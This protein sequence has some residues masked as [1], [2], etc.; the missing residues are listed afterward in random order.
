MQGTTSPGKAGQA[1]E[2]WPVLIPGMACA[3]INPCRLAS[4]GAQPARPRPT[5]GDHRPYAERALCAKDAPVTGTPGRPEAPGRRH[6]ASLRPDGATG[7]GAPAAV[8][9]GMS[10]ADLFA[11]YQ[12]RIRRYILGMVRD[13]AEAEDLTQDVFLQA[14][15]KL[16]SLQD[17]D[18][19]TSW[20]YQIATHVCYD[21]FRRSSRQPR[22]DPLDSSGPAGAGYLEGLTNAEIAEMLGASLATVKIRLHRARRKLQAALAA[23]CDFS[24]DEH[25]VFVCE[26][27]AGPDT[28]ARPS[29]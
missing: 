24:H 23:G 20:L 19:V 25:G 8:A 18:A 29:G 26:R 22:L 6:A 12:G 27:A 1:P 28:T 17:P 9:A 2:V 5:K 21:R 11:A 16:G 13:P 4:P 15:R 7:A 14:H 10:S 3:V